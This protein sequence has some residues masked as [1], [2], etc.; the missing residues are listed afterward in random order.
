MD[1]KLFVHHIYHLFL[2]SVAQLFLTLGHPW[3]AA[4]QAALSFTVSQSL[5]KLMSIEL[6]MPSNHL[7]FCCPL[8]LLPSVFPSIRFFPILFTSI[9]TME[10]DTKAGSSL[11]KD[12]RSL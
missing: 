1:R 3:T 9:F 5:P 11:S 8:L 10:V 6:M 7:I 4:H 2:F 12:V